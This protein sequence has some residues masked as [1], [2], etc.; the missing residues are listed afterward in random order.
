M[1][2][3]GGR[4]GR[5]L[6]KLIALSLFVNDA[7]VGPRVAAVK[8]VCVRRKARVPLP[9]TC[10]VSV[11]RTQV[12][13]SRVWIAQ[14]NRFC[15]LFANERATTWN[16]GSDPRVVYFVLIADPD[17]WSLNPNHFFFLETT[18]GGSKQISETKNTLS[19]SCR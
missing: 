18:D 2:T 8:G 9:C 12:Y 7:N 17:R 14:W 10:C 1:V 4:E 11:T 13:R 16:Q 15:P 19:K 3:S 5:P 6:A